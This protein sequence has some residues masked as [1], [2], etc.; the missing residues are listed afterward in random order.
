MAVFRPTSIAEAVSALAAHPEACVV[1]G[2]TD[3][4]VAVRTG[5]LT[6]TDVLTVC[7][8]P[9]LR[10]VQHDAA[11]ASLRIGAATTFAALAQSPITEL[12]P[13]LA[14]AA[15]ALGSVQIRNAA[16]IGGSVGTA[17]A[18]GDALVVLVA[19]GATVELVS[20]G[21]SRTVPVSAFATA[22]PDALARAGELITAVEVPV[23][24]GAQQFAKVT[25]RAAM[26]AAIVNGAVVV[27]A[28]AGAVR[29]ALGGVAPTVLRCSS[30]EAWCASA[31][32]W[33]DPRP[34]PVVANEFGRRVAEAVAP[35][36]D[37]RATAAY[38]RH[39]G[40]VLATRLLLRCLA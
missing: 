3:V 18:N 20:H 5:A 8:M 25:P 12:A 4:M 7:A 16:T 29:I 24:R 32:D 2:G 36:D 19:L 35:H 11:R 33:T 40:G 34:D 9:E 23:Y 14:Q 6:L 10:G 30:A 31:I 26:A 39:A 1:A 15:R 38:R 28:D 27:D 37:G 22:E 17:A 13:A 21:G